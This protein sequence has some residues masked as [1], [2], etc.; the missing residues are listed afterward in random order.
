MKNLKKYILLIISLLMLVLSLGGCGKKE[1]KQYTKTFIALG[2][3]IN[4]NIFSHNEKEAQLALEEGVKKV[5]EIENKMSVNIKQSEISTLNTNGQSKV[6]DETFYVIKNGLKYSKIA[7]GKFDITVEPLVRI[8]GIGTDHARIPN[9]NEIS[10]AKKLINY[11]NVSLD[12]KNNKVTLGRSQQMDLGAIAK[13]YAADE[14]KKVFLKH[15]I[16]SGTINLG[17][18]VMT[19]GNKVDGSE[20]KIGMQ[21]PFGTRDDCM[22]IVYGKNLSVVTSGNY[23]RYFEKDGVRY[24]HILDIDTG[25]PSKSEVISATIISENGIDGDALSTTVYIL[26]VEKGLELIEELKGI[27][28]ILITKD[29]KVYVTKNIKNKFQI[30]DES[31]KLEN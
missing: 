23:E 5:K 24:H 22:G 18:N 27:D 2:T 31:F 13:G 11:N 19:I 4:F 14:A 10:N 26:G 1:V 20:W 21:N 9:N 29:R 7:K 12:E 25:Y 28:A 17:G 30:I 3:A 8:W 15:N 6:S 16:K